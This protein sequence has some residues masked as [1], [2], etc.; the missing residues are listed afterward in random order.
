MKRVGNLFPAVYAFENLADAARRASR[1]KRQRP[2]VL[3]F[4]FDWEG[5]CWQLSRELATGIWQPSPHRHFHIHDPKPRWISAAP[6]SDRVVHHALC[7]VVEPVLDR[8]LIY[9][10]WA[11]RAGKGSHRAVL[12]YQQLA[13]RYRYVLK[14]DIRKYFPAIDHAILKQQLARRFKDG[15]LLD[16]MSRIIDHGTV[17]EPFYAHFAG[18]DLFTPLERPKGLPIGN[19]TSQLW[20]N[21][22]LA[23]FDHWVK[24]EFQGCAYVRFVDDFLVLA[25]DKTCLREWLAAIEEKLSELRLKLHPRKCVIRPVSEG[26]PFLGY[27]VWRDRIRV[28]GESVRRFRRGTRRLAVDDETRAARMQ[29]WEGHTRLA[30]DWRQC[31]GLNKDGRP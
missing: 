18:D 19:L 29:A 30:G 16:L 9:D 7:Q 31:F 13:R 23:A 25:Q 12:R 8:G 6:F 27:V 11:S 10:C 5:A 22:Y 14:A 2:D 1:G 28:R 3:R 4:N 21:T 26:V 17:P 24:R 20:A 15:P